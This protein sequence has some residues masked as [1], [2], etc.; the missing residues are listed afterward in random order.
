MH[1][2]F[3]GTLIK[4]KTWLCNSNIVQLNCDHGSKKIYVSCIK[5]WKNEVD[6]PENVFLVVSS[7]RLQNNFPRGVVQFPLFLSF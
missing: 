5:K 1:Q 4:L 2:W 7:L 3:M 6:Y